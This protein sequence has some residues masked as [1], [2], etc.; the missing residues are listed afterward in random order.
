[1][2]HHDVTKTV[3]IEREYTVKKTGAP[4]KVE[5]EIDIEDIAQALAA[6]AI[7]AKGKKSTGYRGA[8]QCKV[9][10]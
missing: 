2:I 7:H 4:F 1:M 9:I 3:R 6:R 8:I 10:G 5:I